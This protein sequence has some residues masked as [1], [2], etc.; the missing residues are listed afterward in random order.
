M[1]EGLK[2]VGGDGNVQQGGQAPGALEGGGEGGVYNSLGEEM[3]RR[4]NGRL[5]CWMERKGVDY[6]KGWARVGLGLGRKA[7]WLLYTPL[8]ITN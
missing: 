1:R 2:G 8:Y 5:E 7:P 6:G 4:A 3:S